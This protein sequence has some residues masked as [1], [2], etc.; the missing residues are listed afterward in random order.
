MRLRNTA[1]QLQELDEDTEG[2]AESITK[3][4]TQ[5]LNLTSGRVN[6][7][8]DSNTFKSTYDIMVELADVWEDLSDIQKADVT[9]LVAGV[10]Q[11]NIF[12]SMLTNM[13]DGISATE[14]ALNSQG[15]ALEENSK[16]LDSIAGKTAQ[17]NAAFETLSSNTIDSGLMKSIID[18]T[19][20]FVEF[21]DKVGLINIA[22][23]AFA[24]IVYKTKGLGLINWLNKSVGGL[25]EMTKS[26]DSA[27]I[28]FMNLGS[29]LKGFAITAGIALITHA[30][31]NAIQK[32]KELKDTF[33]NLIEEAQKSSSVYIEN[34]DK[35]NDL[36]SKL[37]NVKKGSE[38]YF[39]ITQE[40]NNII[41]DFIN[42][43]DD[44]GRAYA[45]TKDILDQYIISLNDFSENLSG[46]STYSISEYTKKLDGL[47]E[48]YK[49]LK[50]EIPA[51]SGMG[52][53]DT[54]TFGLIDSLDSE[55]IRLDKLMDMSSADDMQKYLKEITKMTN[56]EIANLII[57]IEAYKIRIQSFKN[58]VVAG[59]AGDIAAITGIPHELLSAAKDSIANSIKGID[60]TA[61]GGLDKI[62]DTAVV[63]GEEIKKAFNDINFES[64]WADGQNI[65]SFIDFDNSMLAYSQLKQAVVNY[66][67]EQGWTTTQISIFTDALYAS[68]KATE[69]AENSL[70]DNTQAVKEFAAVYK[71]AYDDVKK[72][73]EIQELLNKTG[74]LT[75][76]IVANI[77]SAYPELIGSLNSFESAQQAV[78][79]KISDLSMVMG[80]SYASAVGNTQS[81][82]Q[83][84]INIGTVS[85][86]TLARLAGTSADNFAKMESSKAKAAAI[87]AQ[88]AASVWSQYFGKSAQVIQAQMNALRNV[89]A[90]STDAMKRQATR[91]AY[92]E[93]NAILKVYQA[94]GNIKISG[95]GSSGG[96]SKSGGGSSSS[97]QNAAEEQKSYLD[98]LKRQFDIQA[99][100]WESQNKIHEDRISQIDSE[101][102]KQNE[103][104]GKLKEQT[105]EE[106]MQLQ[107]I[108]AQEKLT[109]IRNEKIKLF[110]ADAGKFVWAEDTV[111]VAEQQ[112]VVDR[113]E[114]EW[115][116]YQKEKAIQATINGLKAEKQEQQ[117][118]IDILKTK[119]D[120][121]REFTSDI[122]LLD[123]EV[124]NNISTWQQLIAELDK[125]QIAYNN[126][127]GVITPVTNADQT[128]VGATPVD[129]GSGGG[130]GTSGGSGS[131]DSKVSAVS[132]TL[133]R[134]SKDTEGVKKLQRA[135]NALGF[136][137]LAVDGSFGS[138]T[139][140]AVKAFQKAN[141]LSVDGSVGSKTKGVFAAKGY[142]YGGD[143]T[144]DGFIYAHNKEGVLTPDINRA[145]K[146]FIYDQMPLLSNA[147]RS[148]QN[149]FTTFQGSMDMGN[150]LVIKDGT[151]NFHGVQNISQMVNQLRHQASLNKS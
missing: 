29:A 55:K 6:I 68:K 84:V 96:S 40:L 137:T 15:S 27:K 39:N 107:L 62:R 61:E 86:N 91:D 89:G 147:I 58:E 32:A 25:K 118:L 47:V 26:V 11:G 67:R 120:L 10:R 78:N 100:I 52:F 48:A 105:Q 117:K 22:L 38:E 35:I 128:L 151:F 7:M 16:Y 121:L 116:L 99:D 46:F 33:K 132:G 59:V 134:G 124:Q 9:R 144:R 102:D 28:G 106:D 49:A 150:G 70:D 109:N 75:P 5:L 87:A 30:I 141:K 115:D 8:S 113:L 146:T 74:E 111:K 123:D 81:F 2:A 145:F 133:K 24:V 80:Q 139:D 103:L 136:G 79:N 37:G 122:G 108:K 85:N 73:T 41:P 148:M 143:V 71:S 135:L 34:K 142:T 65:L 69:E 93:L 129:G 94:I 64:V 101:I 112:E 92:N 56:T 130:G 149:N 44:N 98:L 97:A 140:A 82:W 18:I 88:S 13:Q 4:Q 42:Y 1:G 54:L 51:Q 19:R 63:K 20:G 50:Y 77:A 17:L 104:L 126:V 125:A 131:E 138:K 23:T 36:V 45:K 60:A 14:T 83:Q 90:R 119:Q 66:G 57:A 43:V 110:S 3:L 76:E 12:N 95:G 127:S 72:L 21:I 114:R 31:T 53:F